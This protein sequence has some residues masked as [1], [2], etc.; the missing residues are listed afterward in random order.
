MSNR[1]HRILIY[2]HNSIGLGHT[3]RVLAII[4]GIKKWRPDIDFLVV[5]GTSVP[6]ILLRQGIE[7]IKLPSVK[8][9]ITSEGGFLS[10][11]YLHETSLDDVLEYR[12]RAIAGS[13]D[14]FRPDALMIEHY[15]AG[16]SGEVTPLLARKKTCKGTSDEFPLVNISRGILGG[17][18]GSHEGRFQLPLTDYV[19]LY[20]FMYVFDD[21]TTIDVNREFLGNDPLIESRIRYVGRITDK[22][23]DELPDPQEVLKRFRLPDKPIILMSLSRHGDISALS[24][25]LMSAFH[26]TGLSRLSQIIMIIDPYLDQNI[27]KG[28]QNDPLFED[29]RFLPFFYPL[30]DLI[31]VSKLV[32]CRAGYNIINEILLTDSRAL[33]IPEHH[34]GGEQERRACLIPKDNV[35]VM[36]EEEILASLPD[37][38]LLD[39]LNRNTV[40]LHFSF[41]KY[42]IGKGII[43]DLEDW[44]KTRQP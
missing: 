41:D 36:T 26:R 28:L 39:L 24:R 40:P 29:V 16:L 10:P 9:V 38:I 2:T 32:V 19:S 7:V 44:A 25:R 33:I 5:S 31:H 14:F 13:F 22:H 21:K 3:F 4:T 35:I 42:Q 12:K 1:I 34:P 17:A 27:F 20:D 8:K 23:L 6:H 18:P 11:R 15:I 37:H 43:T 30:I